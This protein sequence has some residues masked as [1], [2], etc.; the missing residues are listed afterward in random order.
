MA[1]AIVRTDLMSGTKNPADLVSVK[2][3]GA[4]GATA[5]AID[6]GNVVL[7]AGLADATN[8][9]EVWVGKTPAVNSPIADIVLIATP[10]VEYDERKRVLSDFQNPLG[11]VSRGYR[12]RSGNV[13]SVTAD[14]LTGTK[15]TDYIVELDAATKLKCVS[16]LTSGSTKVGTLIGNET[17]GGVTYYIIKIA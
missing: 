4:N 11:A 16:S 7:L 15:T 17:V 12:L 3:L 5:T 6:N 1:Y 2:Y 13:F 14:A 8:D 9:R 10:E